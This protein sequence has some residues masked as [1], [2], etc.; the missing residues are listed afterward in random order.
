MNAKCLINIINTTMKRIKKNL[1]SKKKVKVTNN[2]FISKETLNAQIFKKSE[3]NT[4]SIL[5]RSVINE[6]FENNY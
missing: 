6:F 4:Q 5:Y 1:I 2:F 3:D